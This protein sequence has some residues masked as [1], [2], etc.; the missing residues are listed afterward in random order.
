[1]LIDI[2]RRIFKKNN[3]KNKF[4]LINI[5]KNIGE[6]IVRNT[7]IL[8][9]LVSLLSTGTV[10]AQDADTENRHKIEIFMEGD[11]GTL[12]NDTT[13]IF[14]GNDVELGLTYSYTVLPYIS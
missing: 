7:L 13:G 2:C 11:S 3:D 1:M 6:I 4:I 9:G 12:A 10:F 8:L 14:A 5:Y